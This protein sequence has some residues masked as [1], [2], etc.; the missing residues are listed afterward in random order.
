MTSTSYGL[1]ALVFIAVSM[2]LFFWGYQIRNEGNK[3]ILIGKMLSRLG[4]ELDQVLANGQEGTLAQCA[5]TCYACQDMDECRARLASN[6]AV[7]YQDICPNSAF[8]DTF[9]INTH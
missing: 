8:L 3:K 5:R 7:K 9:Q 4:I 6:E 2:L 1:L